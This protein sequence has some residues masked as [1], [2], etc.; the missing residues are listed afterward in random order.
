MQ[1]VRVWHRVIMEQHRTDRTAGM[2]LDF[3][4]A[5]LAGRYVNFCGF[6]VFYY[7]P[8]FFPQFVG[9]VPIKGR[10]R[11]LPFICYSFNRKDFDATGYIYP[12]FQNF[13]NLRIKHFSH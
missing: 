8:R 2:F 6:I 11:Q 5:Y 10:D 13:L 1:R 9:I 4:S 3:H 12:V 7:E